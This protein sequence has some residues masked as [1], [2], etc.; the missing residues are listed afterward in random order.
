MTGFEKVLQECLHEMDE[1]ASGLEECLSR[2][3]RYAAQLR[4]I[5]LARA[6]LE[7][8]GAVPVSEEFK[9]RVRAK[10]MQD[11]RAHPRKSVRSVSM[12]L[13][14][15]IS[16]AATLLTLLA[17]GTAFAQGALPGNAFYTWKLAS[18]SAWRAVSSDPVGTDLKIAARRADELIAVSKDPMLFPG[19]LK[20]YLTTAAR[21]KS[22]ANVENKT[23][24][25]PLL[26]SQMRKISQS[27]VV[28]PLSGNDIAPLS[29]PTATPV[30]A[31][32]SATSLPLLS[33][34]T[35][36]PYVTQLVQLTPMPPTPVPGTQPKSAPPVQAPPKIIPTLHSPPNIAP[37]TRSQIP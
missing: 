5:L 21:L 6:Y 15:S 30:A 3:P 24:I 22:E 19:A 14:F 10:V 28:L 8:A 37:T 29:G 18:E 33:S 26:D 35:P 16:L 4:P 11:V 1:G 27:G 12:F 7:R 23:R 32:S 9:T 31:P 20:T 13:R 2:H 34:P 17:T 36:Q 25:L